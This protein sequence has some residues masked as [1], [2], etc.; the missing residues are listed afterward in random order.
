MA[1]I[2]LNQG[3]YVAIPDDGGVDGV[4]GTKPCQILDEI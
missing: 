3:W 4:F 2:G 1:L